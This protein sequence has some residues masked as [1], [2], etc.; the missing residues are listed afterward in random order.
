MPA[1]SL[2]TVLLIASLAAACGSSS[3]SEDPTP[4]IL[5]AA[6]DA[7]AADAAPEAAAGAGGSG[8]QSGNPQCQ[9]NTTNVACNECLRTT[10]GSECAACSLDTDCAALYSCMRACPSF[11]CQLDCESQYQDSI[12]TLMSFLGKGGCVDQ[13]CVGSCD[14]GLG[15]SGPDPFAQ[16]RL[17]CFEK[18][19]ELRAKAGASAVAHYALMEPCADQQAKNDGNASSS[20]GNL[21]HCQQTAQNECANLDGAPEDAVAACLETLF[22]QGPGGAN[23]DNLTDPDHTQVACGFFVSATG[24]T[25]VVQN[26]Y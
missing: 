18:T 6:T 11:Q 8:G 23:Y 22:A 12:V 17:L 2:A 25:W 20:G 10:C 3:S 26:F 19:N 16:A 15:S 1:R 9:F 7:P 14:L 13:K 4:P 5:D 21:P 24:K